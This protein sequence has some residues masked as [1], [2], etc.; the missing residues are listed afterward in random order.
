[1]DKNNSDKKSNWK[2]LT[3]TLK[4]LDDSTLLTF[5]LIIAVIII[6]FI[7]RFIPVGSTDSIVLNFLI[8]L[9]CAAVVVLL[10]GVAIAA[11]VFIGI[12]ITET[13]IDVIDTY[14]SV[15]SENEIMEES[16]KNMIMAPAPCKVLKAYVTAGTK[17]K[18]N[19]VLFVIEQ[20][21][22][23]MELVAPVDGTIL[24]VSATDGQM[25]SKKAVLAEYTKE[26]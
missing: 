14:K 20:Q 3:E 4:A 6:L 19:Q 15:K 12:K 17:V 23:E 16:E 1:M 10:G 22:M 2:V 25:V 11:V 7:S 18:K 13:I 9:L 26:E 24:T 21:K 5:L 8:R